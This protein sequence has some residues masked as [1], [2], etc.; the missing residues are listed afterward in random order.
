MTK[1]ITNNWKDEEYHGTKLSNQLSKEYD[2]VAKDEVIP[3][4]IGV[5]QKEM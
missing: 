3:G 2:I 5:M 1:M 4:F